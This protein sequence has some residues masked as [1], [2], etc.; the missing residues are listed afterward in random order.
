MKVCML[1]VVVV[2][3]ASQVLAADQQPQAPA[4]PGFEKLKSLVGAWKGK[5]PDGEEVQTTYKLVGAGSAIEEILSH[6]NMITM[7]HLDGS[8]LMLTHYCAAQNQ[9]RMRA[10]AYKD[11]GDALKFSFVDATNMSDSNAVHMHNLAF[12]F[13]DKDHFTQEWT[14]YKDGKEGQKVV[15]DFERVK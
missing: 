6:G 4:N 2:L 7:Y 3:F 11:G 15:I 1:S 9:P 14:M 8:S 5:M 12:L 10:A 13:R